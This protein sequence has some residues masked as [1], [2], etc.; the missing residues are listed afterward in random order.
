MSTNKPGNIMSLEEA[1][2]ILGIKDTSNKEEI[3]H[4]WRQLAKK[5]HPDINKN[6]DAKSIMQEIN[7]AMETIAEKKP[8]LKINKEYIRKEYEAIK[9][10]YYEQK[11]PKK[12]KQPA[13]EDATTVDKIYYDLLSDEITDLHELQDAL[14]NIQEEITSDKYKELQTKNKEDLIDEEQKVKLASEKIQ[15]QI[16]SEINYFG[17]R[18][19][20]I[21]KFKDDMKHIITIEDHEDRLLEKITE[22][23]K[24]KQGIR[25]AEDN[26]TKTLKKILPKIRIKQK[27]PYI[28]IT[29]KINGKKIIKYVLLTAGVLAAI[30]AGK[31]TYNHYKP[32]PTQ[33][34][35]LLPRW[36]K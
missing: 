30:L 10:K 23:L 18:E 21:S 19:K 36:R 17:I 9:K 35:I 24:S 34:P 32:Q 2:K 3:K 15:R 8:E 20:R 25:V 5:Y 16:A 1:K 12:E 4:K 31:Y 33:K 11:I 28:P 27:K 7:A 26:I 6:P 14:Q 22:E 13:P 29:K